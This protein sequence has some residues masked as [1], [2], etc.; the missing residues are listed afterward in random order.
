MRRTPLALLISLAAALAPLVPPVDAQGAS[1]P[2][3]TSPHA[4]YGPRLTPAIRQHLALERD[5]AARLAAA[6][7]GRGV[8][9]SQLR[10]Q[11][12]HVAICEVGGNWAMTGPTFSGIGFSNS[13]WTA[14]GGT[15]YAA[16]AGRATR[17]QQIIIGMRVTGGWVPDQ[18]GSTL[19]GW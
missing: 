1:A 5:T 8:S 14:Y 18:Y 7:R 19:G 4:A 15:R 10:S 3:V 6:A 16:L 17:D 11:W 13:T 12:Q 9:V 2:P